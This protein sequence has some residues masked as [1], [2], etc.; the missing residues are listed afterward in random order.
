MSFLGCDAGVPSGGAIVAAEAKPL[1]PILF[2]IR[3]IGATSS[4][5]KECD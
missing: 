2:G 4:R 5:R 1:N 3:G